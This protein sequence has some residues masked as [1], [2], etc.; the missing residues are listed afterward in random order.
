MVI[1]R[2]E[3]TRR[4]FL[5]AAAAAS[6]A[7]GLAGCGGDDD[8]Q[9]AQRATTPTGGREL[10]GELKILQWSHFVPAYDEWFDNTYVTEWGEANGVRVTVDHVAVADIGPRAAAEVAAQSGHDLFGFLSPPAAYEDQVID[11]TDIIKELE[12]KVGKYSDLGHK[13]TFNPKTEKYFGVSDNYVPDPVVYR[14][15]LW[16]EIGI[17]PNT[18]DDVLRAAPQLREMGNPIGIGMANELDSNM[19]LIALS[20]CFGSFIQDEDANVT[21]DSPETVEAVEFGAELFKQGMTNEIFAWDPAANNRF[22]ES[23][24]G[25]MIL[26]AISATRTPEEQNPELAKNLAL[27][28]IPEGPGG[29]LGLE[30]VMGVY[31]IWKFA[32]NQD[33]ARQFVIDLITSYEDAF[34][35]S[36][37][38][39]FPS[40]PESVSDIEGKLANDEVADPPDKYV[41]LGEIAQ[42]AT[43]NVGHPGF[44]NAAID[45]TFNTFLIPQMFAQAARGQMSAQES[46]QSIAG[47]VEQIFEKWRGQG[48]I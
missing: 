31:V 19:A 26:N 18:W 36:K 15:D 10:G 46:V 23:G 43:H 38:Y 37:F 30:H 42:T 8:D 3:L 45:E 14:K 6:A 39:N 13:S 34:T 11:H 27:A 16:D 40:F 48:K 24:K 28:P 35:N 1:V 29:R 22:I 21:L 12:S 2:E 41:I 9:G 25:S 20:M 44:S 17:E 5:K 33:A 32:S 4:D 47:Q 7:L